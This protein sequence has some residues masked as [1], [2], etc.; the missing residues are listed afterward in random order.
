MKNK[1]LFEPD[2]LY[3]DIEDRIEH[4]KAKKNLNFTF[5]RCIR[6]LVFLGGAG[7]TVLFKNRVLYSYSISGMPN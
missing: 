3:K 4:I 6:M 2:I 1:T 5:Y 7:V